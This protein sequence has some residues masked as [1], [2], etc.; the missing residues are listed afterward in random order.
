V[1][2][3][4]IDLHNLSVAD[5]M[6]HLMKY[7]NEIYRKDSIVLLDI[8]HGYGSKGTG[9]KIKKKV[10][11]YV[12]ISNSLEMYET[13]QNPGKTTVKVLK[14]IDIF[15]NPK[16]LLIYNFIKENPRGEKKIINKFRSFKDREVKSIL[17]SL[18]NQKIIDSSLLPN[19]EKRY[20]IK[21]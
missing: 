14:R 5:S 17:K 16:A 10:L 15:T 3:F 19:G 4:E 2:R 1:R 11:E 20:F 21:D 12:S 9:G 13:S 7:I 6:D 18:I 8:I